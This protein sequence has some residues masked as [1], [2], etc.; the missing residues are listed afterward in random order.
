MSQASRRQPAQVFF[1][2]DVWG[3]KPLLVEIPWDTKIAED[4][5]DLPSTFA[6]RKVHKS[7]KASF[8]SSLVFNVSSCLFFNSW[9]YMPR[10]MHSWK[11]PLKISVQCDDSCLYFDSPLSAAPYS[12]LLNKFQELKGKQS[13]HIKSDFCSLSM[14][15]V[16]IT[17]PTMT[18]SWLVV[19]TNSAYFSLSCQHMLQ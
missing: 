13:G 7:F 15:P 4:L 8:C 12:H 9:T 10:S 11:E 17:S 6:V 19:V 1:G 2:P 3:R 14:W 5:P 18:A 16:P